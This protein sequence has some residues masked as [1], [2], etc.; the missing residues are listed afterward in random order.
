MDMDEET[1]G[2]FQLWGI[3]HHTAWAI[4]RN[5]QNELSDVGA[6]LMQVAVMVIVKNVKGP[7]TPA[8]I[9]RWLFREPQ[10][11]SSLLNQME[12][13]G[14]LRKSKDLERKN[15]VRV[16]LTEKGEQVYRRSLDRTET[17][18]EIMS[19]LTEEERSELEKHLLKLRAQ[20]LKTL[21]AKYRFAPPTIRPYLT[22][23]PE[24]Q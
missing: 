14:L 12:R 13:K 5:R 7:I 17:L 19:C 15:M 24:D 9:S 21:G 16:E 20:A 4:A 10:T 18:H 23:Y 8:E 2:Y 6:T 3:L 11:V 1:W 22:I